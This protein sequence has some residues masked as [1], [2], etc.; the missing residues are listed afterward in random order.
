MKPQ[1]VLELGGQIEARD[2]SG[3]TP[4]FLACETGK[5]GCACALLDAGAEL[6]T[7]NSGGEAPLYIAALRGHERIVEELLRAFQERGLKWTVSY[8]SENLSKSRQRV[9]MMV[10]D[11]SEDW[12]CQSMLDDLGHLSKKALKMEPCHA[13]RDDQAS[14]HNPKDLNNS[15]S[16]YVFLEIS[17]CSNRAGNCPSTGS[18]C[19]NFPLSANAQWY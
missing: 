12:P 1:V 11:M 2:Q 16:R 7:R 8:P 17:L 6:R 5:L 4:L 9:D 18:T 10:K 15:C 14:C 3:A 13:V 19:C